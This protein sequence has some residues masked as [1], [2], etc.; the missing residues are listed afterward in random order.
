MSKVN[1]NRR[2]ILNLTNTAK[3]FVLTLVL[4]VLCTGAAL[5][6]PAYA[7]G[8]AIRVTLDGKKLSFD[9]DPII[10]NGRTLVPVR[11]IF[12]AC[13]ADVEWVQAT[14]TINASKGDSFIKMILGKPRMFVDG[15]IIYL[16]AA[17]KVVA[18]RTLVPLRAVS[19]ALGLDVKW[20][21]A[22]RTVELSSS[23][24]DSDDLANKKQGTYIVTSNRD[25]NAE[26]EIL[27]NILNV[28]FETGDGNFDYMSVR[29]C[30]GNEP[31]QNFPL[32]EDRRV[33]YI[34]DGIEAS[35]ELGGYKYYDVNIIGW[36]LTAEGS[37]KG[38]YL[39]EPSRLIIEKNGGGYGFRNSEYDK[40]AQTL[41]GIGNPGSH[42]DLGH[43][44]AAELAKIKEL[45]DSI[46]RGASSEYQK[47]RLIHDWIAKNIYYDYDNM[48]SENLAYDSPDVLEAKKTVCGGFSNLYR[49][50][51]RS[52]NIPCTVVIGLIKR[53]SFEEFDAVR[54]DH[55]WNAAFVDG[56]WIFVDVTWDTQNS[57]ENGVF[58]AGQTR[59]EYFDIDFEYFTHDHRFDEIEHEAW[60][61]GKN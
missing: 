5:G 25:D 13:G 52:Q 60:R 20:V 36:A 37:Y 59:S 26:I 51:L 27:G 15:K 46:C 8:D 42:L 35:F 55:G 18:G 39:L 45:S 12:E 57:V 38:T 30:A 43:L 9:V 24:I 7:V 19:E 32:V 48:G 61:Y 33:D 47:A 54:R 34:A 10:E 17:P 11:A 49:D 21:G 41:M 28:D 50:M 29:L 16:D 6:N 44:S 4:S 58:K 2:F 1:Q 3:L 40:S 53:N 22:V 14:S 31:S 56:R 23:D